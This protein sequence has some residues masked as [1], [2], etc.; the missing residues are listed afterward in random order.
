MDLY[1]W[2]LFSNWGSFWIYFEKS[3]QREASFSLSISIKPSHRGPAEWAKD[4][5]EVMLILHFTFFFFFFYYVCVYVGWWDLVKYGSLQLHNAILK[6][7]LVYSSVRREIFNKLFQNITTT[8]PYNSRYHNQWCF[9][10]TMYKFLQWV[11][12]TSL[13]KQITYI[14]PMSI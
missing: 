7:Q 2:D 12:M 11:K 4:V 8:E 3:S 9:H 6:N 5:V 10:Q 14:P 13:E 1:I